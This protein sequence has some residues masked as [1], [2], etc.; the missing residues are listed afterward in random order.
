MLIYIARRRRDVCRS[1]NCRKE[2]WGEIMANIKS[3]KKRIKVID[4]KTAQ[5]KRVKTEL[6]GILKEYDAMIAGGDLEAAEKQ[7]T[8]AEKKLMQAASKHVISKQ[9]ASRHVSQVTK[10]LNSAK[11]DN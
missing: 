10:K 9:A 8:L 7:R 4:K 3:A 6:K 5:N 11:A 2:Q 1:Y